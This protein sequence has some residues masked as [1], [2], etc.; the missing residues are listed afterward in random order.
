MFYK[1][2]EGKVIVNGTTMNYVEFGH[3]QKPFIILPG[4]GDGLKTVRGQAITL[5][6]YYRLFAQHFKV[7]IFSRKNVLEKGYTTKDMSKDLNIALEQLGIKNS[8]V[9]GVSQGGMIAQHLAINYPKIVEKLII[10]VS[11]SRENEVIYNTVSRWIELAKSNDYKTL[12]M[13][14]F[15]KT[16]TPKT[17]KKYRIL[18]PLISRMGKPKDFSRFLI[19]ANACLT[20]NTYNE[21]YK[22]KCSTLII[23]GD[24]DKVVGNDASKEMAEKITESRLIIYNGLGHGAYEEAKDFNQQVLD[25]L[26][27]D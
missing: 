10:G 15:K 11:T 20:H 13:D 12:I 18:Y 24:S 26:L 3:G 16:Y 14:T 1:A 4:L 5:A 17:L 21:L 2:R 9:M 27:N 23:G 6:L 7:Y 8:Y 19:Q 25:F 22:I